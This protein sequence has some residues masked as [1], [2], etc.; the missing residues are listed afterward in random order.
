MT[1]GRGRD[2]GYVV[3]RVPRDRRPVL[4]R[5]AGASRRFQVHALVELDVSEAR[6]RIH[7][8]REPLTW[9]AFVIASVARAV[10]LHP[11][12]NARMS[13]SSVITFDRVDI[14]A[15]V[16]RPGQGRPVLDIVVVRGA[17]R[18]GC[19]EIT[20]QL[21][22]AKVGPAAPHPQRGLV[23]QVLRL[24]GPLRRTAIRLAARR[25]SVSATFGPAVG[26]T[27]IGMFTHGWGWAI[28]LAPLTVIATVG[29]VV[30]RPV[31]V[32]GVVVAR[33]MLPLTLSFDHAVVDGAP[34]ARFVET[35]RG[36]VET[37]AA[38][39][40]NAAPPDDRGQMSRKTSIVAPSALRRSARSS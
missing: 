1:A 7:R 19:V 27:S 10:A 17:D 20:R 30:D 14:G 12:V 28:P 32:D 23:A 35:L 13:G 36:L 9:T 16:E 38:L 6:A 4:D 15:T 31:V 26:V 22:E 24:P 29:A 21:H 5:L 37:A 18:L 11:D 2:P 39:D 34:A 3:Q 40:E 8:A 33:P 25:P